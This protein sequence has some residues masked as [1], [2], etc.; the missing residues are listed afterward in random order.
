MILCPNRNLSMLVV[1]CAFALL[2]PTFASANQ[3]TIGFEAEIQTQDSAF[4]IH[5]TSDAGVLLS[6]VDI[7]LGWNMQFDT[8]TG[9]SAF[10]GLDTPL[11]EAVGLIND[12]FKDSIIK[13]FYKTIAG[14]EVGYS[15]LLGNDIADGGT[16]A[17][18]KFTDF[19]RDEAWGFYVDFDTLT[20]NITPGGTDMNRASIT[21]KFTDLTGRFLDTLTFNYGTING[22]GHKKSFPTDTGNFVGPL[23]T[24]DAPNPV[25]EPA[26]MLLFGVGIIGLAGVVGRRR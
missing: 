1:A 18:L 19:T 5:N 22:N 15:G 13:P 20:S 14:S 26:T 7:K 24:I 3:I 11:K 8:T 9:G 6:Q 23:K 10:D 4:S 21:V 12:H 25:P 17:T 16:S 2:I